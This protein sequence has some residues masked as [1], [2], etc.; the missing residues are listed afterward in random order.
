MVHSENHGLRWVRSFL[1]SLYLIHPLNNLNCRSVAVAKPSEADVT[2]SVADSATEESQT[3]AVIS[4]LASVVRPPIKRK[5]NE[6]EADM[7]NS[8]A[9]SAAE[10]SQTQ[11][12]TSNLVS[13]VRPHIKSKETE[14]DT[15]KAVIASN[16]QEHILVERKQE[17]A[18]PIATS[19][20]REQIPADIIE[21]E[22]DISTL[23]PPF[24]TQ[25][26]H[27]TVTAV[28]PEKLIPAERKQTEGDISTS[29]PSFPS[30]GHLHYTANAIRPER[31][32]PI[33]TARFDGRNYHSW[34]H[35]M[36]FFLNQL[37]IAYVLSEPCPSISL[38]PEA[39]FEEKV[40]VKAAVQRWID[41]DYMCR[42]NILN[43]LC[44]NL[45]QL[46]S[47]KS[48]SAREL[49]EELKLV[50]DDDFGTKRSQIS[51]Y[52]HFQMVDGV[53]IL[54]QV[55]ELHRIA[56]SVIASGTWIDENFHVSVIVSKL[57]PSWKELRVR[58]MQEEFLPLNML[59][60]RLR[61]EEESHNCHKK[62]TNSKKDH[63]TEPK[64]DYRLGMRK[65]ENKRV[66]F[67]CG[68][69][70]HIIKNCPDRKFEASKKSYGKENGV[71]SPCTD[72]KIVDAAK[73]K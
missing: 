29:V 22:S 59:M 67:S 37:N 21:T 33:Q 1:F 31:L 2:N 55:Q 61:V 27:D 48:Y 13:I 65:N 14:A 11:T 16:S 49:W 53:S 38:N 44:D 6:T 17:A 25:R 68:K 3:E 34:R 42:H 45:F 69:E 54:D 8:V 60:H 24:P 26:Q 39:S 15:S 71:V 36:E 18:E 63:V 46:Y 9:D 64:L 30:Q 72:T 5:Q 19:D 52:I 73:T 58:L 40:K 23:V 35:Q 47:Q 56:D 10:K 51:K 4:N 66:C 43:S 57:P 7:R 41:D 62:E 70:D 50:Y 20:Y 32:I 12:G 28:R